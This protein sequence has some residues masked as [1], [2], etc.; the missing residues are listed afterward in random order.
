MRE[1]EGKQEGKEE[2]GGREGERAG[3]MG[4]KERRRQEESRPK[5]HKALGVS[6]TDCG[7]TVESTASLCTQVPA[8][9]P[10]RARFALQPCTIHASPIGATKVSP[11]Q[12][13]F[14]DLSIMS[15]PRESSNATSQFELLG[16]FTFPVM[17]P[18]PCL[19]TLE[20]GFI[21]LSMLIFLPLALITSQCTVSL[22]S[23][24]ESL[25]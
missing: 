9:H 25:L 18:H 6:R 17:K 8:G 5:T 4:G 10:R 19:L 16:F 3:K 24:T 21:S 11:Q 20:F 2:E 14:R 22:Q 23:K 15:G 7:N 12:L 13:Q 1:K